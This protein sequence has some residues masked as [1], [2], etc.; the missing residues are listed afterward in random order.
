M[1]AFKLAIL[2]GSNLVLAALGLLALG[3]QDSSWQ[4]RPHA[5]QGIVTSVE[6]PTVSPPD[7]TIAR[8]P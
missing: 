4:A 1:W 3:T 8:L 2:T 5:P 6:V 7:I